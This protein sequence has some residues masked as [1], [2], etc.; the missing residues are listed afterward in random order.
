M[1]SFCIWF[2][3]FFIL[4]L[5]AQ[6]EKFYLITLNDVNNQ[7]IESNFCID[8]IYDGRQFKENIGFAQKSI[9]NIKMAINFKNSLVDEFSSFLNKLYPKSDTKKSISIRV[10]DVYLTESTSSNKETGYATVVVDVIEKIGNKDYIVGSYSSVVESSSADVTSKHSERL[11]SAIKKCFDDYSSLNNK[12]KNPIY[13]DPLVVGDTTN[14]QQSIKK[15]IYLNYID[16][17]NRNPLDIEGY[18]ITKYR[19]G[20]VY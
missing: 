5:N 1:K 7:K 10:N 6:N 9:A 17:L 20:I 12:F 19:K 16:V 13:F 2:N 14:I 4:I 18:T 15:G 8:K 11:A 3:L